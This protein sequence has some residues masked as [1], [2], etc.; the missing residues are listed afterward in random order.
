MTALTLPARIAPLFWTVCLATPLFASAS[1]AHDISLD[2]P[3]ASARQILQ[4]VAPE[5]AFNGASALRDAIWSEMPLTLVG[6]EFAE[7]D[8]I[9]YRDY[10]PR[11]DA[12]FQQDDTLNLYLEPIGYAHSEVGDDFRIALT[13]DVVI[14]TPDGQIIVSQEDLAVIEQVSD[15]K[16][17]EFVAAVSLSFTE[18][19]A[20]SYNLELTLNDDASAKTVSTILPFEVVAVAGDEAEN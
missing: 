4:T 6:I 18:F 9:G 7:T 13:V 1:L 15:N 19:P 20:G 5:A 8:E 12:V 14:S 17:Y 16:V 2:D 11:A 10:T 3:T